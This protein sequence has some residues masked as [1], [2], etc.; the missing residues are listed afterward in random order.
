MFWQIRCYFLEQ[1]KVQNMACL[2]DMIDRANTAILSQMAIMIGHKM[3]SNM[4]SDKRTKKS[5]MTKKFMA[6]WGN[7]PI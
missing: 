4:A 7:F 3:A 2:R 6:S 5:H 1:G